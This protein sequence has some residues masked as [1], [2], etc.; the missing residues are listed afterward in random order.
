M[1]FH[2]EIL[3]CH[4]CSCVVANGE[5]HELSERKVEELSEKFYISIGGEECEKESIFHE[6]CEGGTCMNGNICDICGMQE[7]GPMDKVT[8]W[9]RS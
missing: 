1:E 9:R 8:L 2:S 3:T 4:E 7:F 5:G 6:H